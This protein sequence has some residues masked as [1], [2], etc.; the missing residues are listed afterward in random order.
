[1]A[2]KSVQQTKS[3]P[4]VGILV[5]IAVIGVAAIGYLTTR[6]NDTQ[7]MRIDPSVPVGKAESYL[8]GKE[9][10]P[11]QVIEFADFE[12]PACGSWASLTEP[13]V[14]TRLIN[15]GMISLRFYDFPLPMHKNTW[16]ASNA[17]ACA[18]DQGKFIAMHDR[19]YQGQ[20]EWNGEATAKPKGIFVGYAKE[21]GLDGAK[22]EECFDSQRMI[23]R[24]KG[25]RAEAERRLIGQTPTFIIGDKMVPGDVPYDQFK[26]LI[27]DEIAR[28][29]GGAGKDAAKDAG[30][31][32]KK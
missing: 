16:A 7:V 23:P 21:I 4:F 30:A 14:R 2:K 18:A 5:A 31:G 22:F 27:D 29:A 8:I 1:M 25:N 17:A 3:K 26:K 11:I 19:L 15:T 28:K 12:C 20:G 32:A 9:D 10:A 13:D 24:I 6:S